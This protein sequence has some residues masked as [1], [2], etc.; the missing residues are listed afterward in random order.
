MIDEKQFE[1]NQIASEKEKQEKLVQKYRKKK[2]KYAAQIRKKQRAERK[3]TRQIESLIRGAIKKSGNKNKNFSLTPAAKAL[4]AQFSA[5]KGKLPWPVTKGLVTVR[6]GKQPDPIDSKLTIESSGVR[7]ATTEKSSARAV[8]KGKVMAI[9]KNPQNGTLSVLI[10]HGNYITV[11][12]N[13]EKV[14]V[15]KGEKVATK[16][17]LGTIHTDRVTG[18]TILKFQ[19]WADVIKQN[20][21]NWVYK[22]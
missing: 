13:L 20:P 18:K 22:M 9:L 16:Q 6:F 14:S 11:Y 2:Q 8:F 15:A 12:A 10:Q 3:L 5:N 17:K 4:A 1:Q 7:I 21:A 19:I